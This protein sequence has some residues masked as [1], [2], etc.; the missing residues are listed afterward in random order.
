MTQSLPSALFGARDS[1][2]IRDET[3]W[4]IFSTSARTFP[5]AAAATFGDTT[6][7]YAQLAERAQAVA[8]ALAAR[9]I[10]RGDF[11]GLWM[12]RSLDL[13]V[14]LLGILAAGAAYIPFDT[15]A[16]AERVAECLD[17]CA[18][19]AL[20]V[21][22]FTMGAITGA[23]PAHTLILPTLEQGAPGGA[24]PDPRAQGANPADPAYAIY[25]S[26]STGKPKAIVISH[27]N[28]CHYLRAANSLYGL[29]SDDVVFQGASVAFDLSLE[30]IFVPYLVGAKLWIAGRRTWPR[31]TACRRCWPRPASPC[32]TPCRPC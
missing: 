10:G 29:R 30:E 15:E 31:P 32:W 23:M 24:S 6:L 11:V 26:G 1:S 19:K 5:S 7:T 20:I 2:L 18:A 13:H 21:D 22:A 12:S 28:I 27:F 9:G 8:R 17:D 16:P 4:E 3:L 25:T 14:A